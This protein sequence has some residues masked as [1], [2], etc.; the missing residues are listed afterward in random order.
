MRVYCGSSAF[1]HLG[2]A[3][4]CIAAVFVSADARQCTAAKQLG[5]QVVAL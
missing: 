5:L 4:A 1:I 2:A 3:L